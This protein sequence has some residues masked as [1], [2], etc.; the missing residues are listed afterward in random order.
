MALDVKATLAQ[1]L[2][3]IGGETIEMANESIYQLQR[4]GRLME[5]YFG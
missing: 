2:V 5:E 1:I 3:K 4:N